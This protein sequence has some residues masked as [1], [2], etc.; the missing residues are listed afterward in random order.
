MNTE[1]L[2]GLTERYLREVIK[3]VC[4]LAKEKKGTGILG[5]V[6]GRPKTEDVRIEI[7]KI[8]EEIF[9]NLLLKSR[10]SVKVFSEHGTYGDASPEYQ[11]AIDPFDGSGLYRRGFEYEW[12]SVLTFFDLK[13]NP[14]VGGTADILKEKIYL[15]NSEKRD[16]FLLEERKKVSNLVRPKKNVLNGQIRLAAYL[17]NPEYLL[18][19]VNKMKGLLD[20]FPS[21]WI[22][23]NGG[24]GIYHMLAEGKVHAYIM[25]N[26]PRSEIDP[27]LAFARAANYPVVSANEDGSYEHYGFL[28]DK[29]QERVPFFLAAST[30]ELIKAIL[31]EIRHE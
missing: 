29:Q 3:R 30:E 1:R 18:S 6:R 27:G 25:C 10:L 7:D 16:C 31:K 26:E 20:K 22:W 4:P 28:P 12:Y 17:M 8:C 9:Q 15:A 23:P 13:G 2:L 11:C 14:L 5:L 24:A 21:I 19:W